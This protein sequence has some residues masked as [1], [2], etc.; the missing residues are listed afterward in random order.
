MEPD[1]VNT[2]LFGSF[3]TNVEKDNGGVYYVAP[4]REGG[5]LEIA[6]VLGVV[7][8]G[9]LAS[10]VIIKLGFELLSELPER[11]PWIY[12]DVRTSLG[13]VCLGSVA[14]FGG[15]SLAY[16]KIEETFNNWIKR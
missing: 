2:F 6:G 3:T 4:R 5:L 13:L 16:M 8:I 14:L 11:F 7:S 15:V 10:G 1:L 12:R 9:L